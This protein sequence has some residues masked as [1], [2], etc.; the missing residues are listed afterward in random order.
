MVE[1]DPE[2]S[3]RWARPRS[4]AR[5]FGTLSHIYD[6]HHSPFHQIKADSIKHL[7]PTFS[8]GAKPM[9]VLPHLEMPLLW[10][11]VKKL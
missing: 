8:A 7:S 4:L 2:L 11:H 3:A 1:V 6:Q 10:H 9:V 5:S